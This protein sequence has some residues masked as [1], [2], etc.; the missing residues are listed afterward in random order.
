MIK[1]AIDDIINN[2]F[3]QDGFYK[4][5]NLNKEFLSNSFYQRIITTSNYNLIDNQYTLKQSYIHNNT[6][7]L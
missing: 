6:D 5:V 7:G 2:K 3:M 1:E 4:Y